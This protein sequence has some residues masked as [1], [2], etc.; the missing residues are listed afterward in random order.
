MIKISKKQI[1]YSFLTI[2]SVLCLFYIA[3]ISH[4]QL[5][6]HGAA[7]FSGDGQRYAQISSFFTDDS[8]INESNINNYR[9]SV[10][11]SLEEASLKSKYANARLWVDCY[12]GKAKVKTTK[13]KSTEDVTMIGVGGDF[14]LFHPMTM[15]EGYYFS[16]NDMMKDR[17]LIDKEVAWQL[18]GSTD[19]IGMDMQVGSKTC[20]VVGVF[21]LS[22]DKATKNA[23][24]KTPMI[25]APFEMLSEVNGVSGTGLGA[26]SA[27]TTSTGTT[28]GGTSN[29][30]KVSC[31]EILLPNPVSGFAKQIMLKN[32][33]GVDL[34]STTSSEIDL[35]ELKVEIL[36]NTNRFSFVRLLET[37]KSIGTRS[38][39]RKPME[40][41]FWENIARA[42]EDIAIIFLRLMILF[43]IFPV[44]AILR[45]G[46]KR[47]R[48]RKWTIKRVKQVMEEKAEVKKKKKWE[49]L[50]HEKEK[51]NN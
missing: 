11:K 8:T 19:V 46:W 36:E 12:S 28:S 23:V 41:P 27:G 40:Y 49:E 45:W 33:A 17:I 15:L 10:Q 47:F 26:T 21:E 48:Q 3:S 32:I 42:K 7:R 20:V 5:S 4:S 43:L 14:F 24:G 31:Y 34:T 50:K 51:S 30:A 1:G 18:F 29:G 16:S 13:G 39:H 38:M 37:M 22:D 44:I 25:Y 9:S 2:L 6:Q 35:E